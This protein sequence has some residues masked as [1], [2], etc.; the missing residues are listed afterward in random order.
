MGNAAILECQLRAEFVG[1]R[2][3]VAGHIIHCKNNTGDQRDFARRSALRFRGAPQVHLAVICAP[4]PAPAPPAPAP[5]PA[6][7]PILRCRRRHLPSAQ[8]KR[9]RLKCG[10][11]LTQRGRVRSMRPPACGAAAGEAR[12]CSKIRFIACSER[13]A[14]RHHWEFHCTVWRRVF[15]RVCEDSLSAQL[16]P[17]LRTKPRALPL[18]RRGALSAAGRAGSPR[19]CGYSLA[20]VAPTS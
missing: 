17:V 2:A 13:L 3:G 14:S 18:L 16:Q 10:G 5:A 1:Q 4:T 8:D 11:C 12:T 19:D 15:A 9:A 20:R 7:A 6:P